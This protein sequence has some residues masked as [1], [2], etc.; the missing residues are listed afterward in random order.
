MD[1]LIQ[2]PDRVEASADPLPPIESLYEQVRRQ[3]QILQGMAV[4]LERLE[5]QQFELGQTLNQIVSWIE[6]LTS[7]EPNVGAGPTTEG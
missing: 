4:H 6:A 7:E 3:G 5:G 2:E 1:K